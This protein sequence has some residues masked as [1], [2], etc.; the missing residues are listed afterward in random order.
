MWRTILYK[1][2]T[3]FQAVLSKFKCFAHPAIRRAKLVL[4]DAHQSVNSDRG[5]TLRWTWLRLMQ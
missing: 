3:Q 2:V 1:R 4:H 5:C